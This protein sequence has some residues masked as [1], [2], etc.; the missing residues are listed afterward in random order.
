VATV[1]FTAGL[2]MESDPQ[3]SKLFRQG[4]YSSQFLR[5][6]VD[7]LGGPGSEFSPDLTAQYL[8]FT[9]L[10]EARGWN[11][12]GGSLLQAGR[13]LLEKGEEL[14][15]KGGE[16]LEKG[17]KKLNN[18]GVTSSVTSGISSYENENL[19]PW[20]RDPSL[21]SA[22]GLEAPGVTILRILGAEGFLTPRRKPWRHLGQLFSLVTMQKAR[23]LVGQREVEL[24]L[25][26]L[27]KYSNIQNII[28][29]Y[30]SKLK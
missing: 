23:D 26:S 1:S 14:M 3:D 12:V 25:E 13:S 7:L 18:Y 27:N 11:R 9:A 28:T 4:D 2:V 20:L 19:M 21:P 5:P 24:I 10:V 15:E 30:D 16:L 17:A 6:V 8:N 22:L 29:K